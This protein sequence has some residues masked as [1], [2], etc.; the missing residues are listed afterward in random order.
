MDRDHSWEDTA[1]RPART[2]ADAL[3][4]HARRVHRLVG[5]SIHLR[6][7]GKRKRPPLMERP[8]LVPDF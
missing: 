2:P 8:Y 4:S 1:D 6:L 5:R 7:S 3:N